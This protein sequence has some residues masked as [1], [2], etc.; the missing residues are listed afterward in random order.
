[1]A[2]HFCRSELI[3]DLEAAKEEC[4]KHKNRNKTMLMSLILTSEAHKILQLI[5]IFENNYMR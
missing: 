4:I 3:Y 2:L 5:G 1:M